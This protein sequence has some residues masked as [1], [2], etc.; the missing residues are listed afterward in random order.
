M[1][2]DH[3]A[4]EENCF[5]NYFRMV[6]SDRNG[7][8]WIAGTIRGSLD[9]TGNHRLNRIGMAC[10]PQGHHWNLLGINGLIGLEWLAHC[11]DHPKIIGF[12]GNYQLIGL[13]W[14]ARRRDHLRD[15]F[16]TGFMESEIGNPV[17]G[18]QDLLAG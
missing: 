18:Q 2:L 6:Q 17:G 5:F 15:D 9:F 3:T 1:K 7:L 8:H 11:R 4:R 12:T 13:E 10:A 16:I 14:P